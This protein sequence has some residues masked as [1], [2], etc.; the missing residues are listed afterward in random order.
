M[1]KIYRTVF[2]QTLGVV[3]VVSEFSKSVSKSKVSKSIIVGST[4]LMVSTTAF[5]LEGKEQ[6]LPVSEYLN[7]IS[8]SSI[9]IE[10]YG[11]I[12]LDGSDEV[13]TINE[14]QTSQEVGGGLPFGGHVG[15]NNGAGL[16]NF[17]TVSGS[18]Y[19][20]GVDG[21]GWVQN[22]GIIEN[23]IDGFYLTVWSRDGD[24]DFEI[25]NT[26]Q[27]KGFVVAEGNN[28]TFGL[29]ANPNNNSVGIFN[30]DTIKFDD[31]NVPNWMFPD[32][33]ESEAYYGFSKFEVNDGS[34]WNLTGNTKLDW[35]INNGHLTG[36][37]NLFDK[38]YFYDAPK[39]SPMTTANIGSLPM[40]KVTLLLNEDSIF[41]GLILG[42]GDV[43]FKGVDQRYELSFGNDQVFNSFLGN[44]HLINIKL[45]SLFNSTVSGLNGDRDTQININDDT[46]LTVNTNNPDT[47]TSEFD[48]TLSGNGN[49]VKDG[50][51]VLVLN[52]D[53]TYLGETNVNG[54]KL[55]VNGNNSSSVHY[56]NQGILGG[57]GTLNKLIVGN[58]GTVAPGSDSS[59]GGSKIGSLTVNEDVTFKEGA[60]YQVDVNDEN[61]M[62]FIMTTQ[63][64]ILEIGST[65]LIDAYG[66]DSDEL[67]NFQYTVLEAGGGVQGEF[68][69]VSV[70]NPF[71]DA[72]LDYATDPNKVFLKLIQVT[73]PKNSY[74]Q[75]AETTNQLAVARTL[76][77]LYSNL[78]ANNRTSRSMPA[79]VLTAVN[80]SPNKAYAL[81]MLSG[82]IHGS[83]LSV[84]NNTVS[85]LFAT[86]MKNLRDNLALTA[87]GQE[88]NPIWVSIE[89]SKGSV[90]K[91]NSTAEVDHDNINVIVGG[92][93]EVG[94]GWHVG[95][96]A[97]YSN[98]SVDVDD[99]KS[100]ADTEGFT[101]MLF[102]GKSF[103]AVNWISATSFTVN[104]VE[105]SRQVD[106]GTG[107]NRI[108]ETLNADYGVRNT[109]L[110]SEVSYTQPLNSASMI[111]P[112]LAVQLNH[113]DS[114]GFTEG[115]GQA[116]LTSG[117]TNSTQFSSLLGL[118]AKTAFELGT[119]KANLNTSLAW[120][121]NY[122]E[123]DVSR[124]LA[125]DGYSNIS[126]FNIYGA[127][128]DE[129]A[130]LVEVGAGLVVNPNAT[131]DLN[132][133]GQFGNRT[134]NNSANFGVK[135]NF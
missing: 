72:V 83:I 63:A 17:G 107:A 110:F 84:L 81:D 47:P 40:S 86:P 6:A 94:D 74:T 61:Q 102:A 73:Q 109:Q 79:N 77:E 127:Q 36:D 67:L 10:Q 55:I 56:V 90:D 88:T 57:S 111:E 126:R 14:G 85:N 25:S 98:G 26:S 105:S 12:I 120:K 115:S 62:D 8:P 2:N 100:T 42:T 54:G 7:Q 134:Q 28:N 66:V 71:F 50:D 51:G 87:L 37:I 18:D 3:Q 101:T 64:I 124:T 118:R 65:I 31:V 4:A 121:H 93:T 131:I 60:S 21:G 128:M 58:G 1:N 23:P 133:K 130:L 97:A 78:L 34:V 41:N 33:D 80:S 15:L 35:H 16:I 13:L 9:V 53:N 39:L 19:P 59:A 45:N 43:E 119:T 129:N 52:G 114:D 46:T 29:M 49:L 69:F 30:T 132:Y 20:I 44:L 75:Y 108:N 135:V 122:N 92:D 27:V 112:F 95:A 91:T 103:G 117:S 106:I 82:E 113:M 11:Q 89:G 104:D 76:D 24:F 125:F 116:S 123:T 38:I 22:H 70:L 48:G 96:A 99:R 32:S 5:S 68:E